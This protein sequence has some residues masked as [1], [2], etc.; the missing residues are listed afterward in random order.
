M[1]SN[2]FK[3]SLKRNRTTETKRNKRGLFN[4]GGQA[5]KFLLGT[6]QDSEVQTISSSVNKLLRNFKTHDL[7]LSLH[8]QLIESN[9]IKLHRISEILS[10]LVNL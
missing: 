8:N 9:T 7:Q 1:I 5:L 6:A 2:M 10:K 4:F 3:W